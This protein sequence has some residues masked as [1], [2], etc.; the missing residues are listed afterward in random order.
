M[1]VLLAIQSS[2]YLAVQTLS[3]VSCAASLCATRS[4]GSCGVKGKSH[5]LMYK[6]SPQEALLFPINIAEDKTKGSASSFCVSPLG[7]TVGGLGLF[8]VSISF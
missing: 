8:S 1:E 4:S 3:E 5:C 2:I 6:L 7:L